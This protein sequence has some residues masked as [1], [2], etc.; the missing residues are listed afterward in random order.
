M[1]KEA[2]YF[3]HDSN[4]RHDAKI[5]RLGISAQKKFGSD[6]AYDAAYGVYFKI[7][8]VMKESSDC[9]L[10]QD[11]DVLK[12]MTGCV[13]SDLLSFVISEGIEIGLFESKPK[14]NGKQNESTM[15]WSES[16]LNRQNLRKS[17]SEAGRKGGRPKAKRKQNESLKEKK[18]KEIK[19]R[20]R[21]TTSNEVVG[22]TAF[23]PVKEYQDAYEGETL[24]P[25]QADL[26]STYCKD[27]SVFRENL[28]YWRG[29]TH[30]FKSAGKFVD[31]YKRLLTEKT[32]GSSAHGNARENRIEGPEPF[33]YDSLVAR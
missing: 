18:G 7:L 6:L 27:E 26:I 9:R 22:A 1:T 28:E 17:R 16:F 31:R 2:Y 14:A 24:D 25:F 23:D 29:N 32:N 8:E 33:D 5:V 3:S 13:S 11:V 4:A 12:V 30:L 20:K 15:F 10:E 21:N 19:E